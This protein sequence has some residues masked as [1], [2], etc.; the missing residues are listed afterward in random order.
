MYAASRKS[1][2]DNIAHIPHATSIRLALVTN[3]EWDPTNERMYRP[4]DAEERERVS[5][6][7]HVFG[8][9]PELT[10]RQ[11][12]QRLEQLGYKGAWLATQAG[13]RSGT[14]ELHSPEDVERIITAYGRDKYQR[15]YVGN[16]KLF[17]NTPAEDG[18]MRC[19]GCNKGGH[20]KRDCDVRRAQPPVEPTG[21]ANA[22]W[23]SR[24]AQ[25]TNRN[26]AVAS[27]WTLPGD[28]QLAPVDQRVSSQDILQQAEPMLRQ[29]IASQVREYSHSALATI[30]KE[31][32]RQLASVSERLTSDEA[33]IKTIQQHQAADAAKTDRMEQM[34][35]SLTNHLLPT[36]FRRG[37]HDGGVPPRQ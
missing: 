10:F 27:G 14:V 6:C 23:R 3:V 15:L 30:K 34:L 32:D 21:R 4:T 37:E 22:Y 5:R 26:E 24:A 31:F 11:V 19:F 13:R 8:L 9:T 16:V 18:S 7:V 35:L 12:E 29:L 1:D 33:L 17:F 36:D 28:Q 20:F 2:R 25:I